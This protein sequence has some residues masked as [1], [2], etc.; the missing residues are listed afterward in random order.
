V[1]K[2]PVG[3]VDSST[4]VAPPVQTA[5]PVPAIPALDHPPLS[6]SPAVDRAINGVSGT[7]LADDD[8]KSSDCTCVDG[9]GSDPEAASRS[10]G[11]VPVTESGGASSNTGVAEDRPSD[12]ISGA[13]DD[14]HRS[15]KSG[16]MCEVKQCIL[17]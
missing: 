7:V 6:A 17:S 5:Q 10:A 4:A 2:V 15:A 12:D 16:R 11:A 8:L 14:R 3:T 13:T 1:P 9:V